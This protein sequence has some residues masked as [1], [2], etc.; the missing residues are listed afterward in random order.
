MWAYECTTSRVLAN[1]QIEVT[2]RKIETRN[3]LKQTCEPLIT[4][5]WPKRRI[6]ASMRPHDMKIS[7]DRVN[8][9]HST[10]LKQK[11]CKHGMAAIRAW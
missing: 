9:G 5:D 11:V 7:H 6:R 10:G 1:G 8:F 4:A 2:T 3:T